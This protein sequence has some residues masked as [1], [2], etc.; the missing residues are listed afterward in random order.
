MI[1]KD[2][3]A[4]ALRICKALEGLSV[5]DS[6]GV[7]A[8]ALVIMAREFVGNRDSFLKTMEKHYDVLIGTN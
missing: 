7:L 5:E 4:T 6:I 3:E 8:I 2:A 1:P